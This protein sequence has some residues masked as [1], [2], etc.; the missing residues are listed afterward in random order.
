MCSRT[1][2]IYKRRKHRI[3]VT[4]DCAVV[5]IALAWS[6]GIQGQ[7]SNEI[8]GTGSKTILENSFN[9]GNRSFRQRSS[10][11]SPPIF[12]HSEFYFSFIKFGF[13]CFVC[14]FSGILIKFGLLFQYVS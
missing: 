2:P 14:I 7:T 8:D 11:D 10:T 9:R 1:R 5:V 13:I 3:L 12:F 6:A 4:A